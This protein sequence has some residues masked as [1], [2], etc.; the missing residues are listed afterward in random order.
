MATTNGS[1][2]RNANG[3]INGIGDEAVRAKTGKTWGQWI[4]TLDKAGARTM[5]HAEIASLLHEKFGVPGWWTQMVTVG[6]ERR[7]EAARASVGVM[8]LASSVASEAVETF[9]LSRRP[10]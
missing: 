10:P 4:A 7:T 3:K 8:S 9:Y 2:A 6:Y 5:E 1:A